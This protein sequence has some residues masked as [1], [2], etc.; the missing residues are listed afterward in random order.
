M[1]KFETP[2]AFNGNTFDLQ[3]HLNTIA[4]LENHAVQGIRGEGHGEGRGHCE[5]N[6]KKNIY[7]TEKP[8]QII[9][10]NVQQN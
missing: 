1:L 4:L 9:Y 10:N 5:K 2:F 6:E 8:N 3:I 7:Y